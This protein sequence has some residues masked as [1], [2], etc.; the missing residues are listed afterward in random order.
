MDSLSRSTPVAP[1]LTYFVYKDLSQSKHLIWN[2]WRMTK[3]NIVKGSSRANGKYS[4]GPWDD[5]IPKLR[6]NF[7]RWNKRTHMKDCETEMLM[8]CIGKGMQIG[9]GFDEMEL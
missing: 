7:P 9:I 2:G 6:M 4:S 5:H 3:Y 8:K 1:N